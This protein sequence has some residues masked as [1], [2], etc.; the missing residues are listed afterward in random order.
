M[1]ALKNLKNH[2]DKINCVEDLFGDG[3]KSLDELRQVS[4][5]FY[6]TLSIDAQPDDLKEFASSVF[7]RFQVFRDAAEQHLA[8][9]T[10][11]KRID[12]VETPVVVIPNGL[13]QYKVGK[14][15]KE[16]DASYLYKCVF[17]ENSKDTV[18]LLKIS[19]DDA[20][21]MAC[22]NEAKILQ[23]L[24]NNQYFPKPKDQFVVQDG[25]NKKQ[26]TVFPWVENVY[27][28]EDIIE[29]YPNGIDLRDAA[30]MFNRMIEFAGLI[31]DAGYT[32]CGL[33]PCNVAFPIDTHGI[34]IIDYLYSRKEGEKPQFINGN[35]RSF[36]PPEV[37][38]KMD[39]SPATDI[40]MATKCMF[41][42]LGG[43]KGVPTT[44]T[45]LLKSCVIEN[46]Y[47]RPDDPHILRKQFRELLEQLYGKPTFR[48]FSMAGK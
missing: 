30:W 43:S 16:C 6:K 14:P 45:N 7:K 12:V 17:Q 18:G 20:N 35:Y 38:G 48:P 24:P 22:Y 23:E 44:I 19:K 25:K 9:G 26:I 36:Y 42:L 32:H 13:K 28:V 46:P 3:V 39:V 37:L 33:L 29:R 15:L 11:G 47:R 10:Y 31:N 2:L 27:T 41:R 8:N 5:E 34:F 21:F 1:S 40:Y 4:R